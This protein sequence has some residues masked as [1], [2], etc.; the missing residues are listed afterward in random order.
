MST[1]QLSVLYDAPGPKARRRA[2]IGS[3]AVGLAVLAV[4]Y[5]VYARLND[6]GQFDRER[7]APLFDPSD[8]LFDPVW[9]I[10]WSGFRKTMTAA[11]LAIVLSVAIG[12][13][14][15]VARVMFRPAPRVPLVVV[16]EVL[17]G[18]PVIVLIYMAYQLLP[19]LGV[20]YDPLPGENAL[21]YV[22]VGL[23]AYNSVVIAE[24]LRA[25]VASL[26]RGQREAGLVIGLTPLQTMV[27][28]QLPQAFRTML[29]ALISQIVVILKDTSLISFIGGYDELLTTAKR[30]F[31]TANNP[32]QTLLLVGLIFIIINFALSQ[33]AVYAERRMSRRSAGRGINP[34]HLDPSSAG[35]TTA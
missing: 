17:R 6:Q 26:P 4:A 9:E 18:L 35:S 19:D 24:I 22:V 31:Q 7:W 11:A 13:I 21:W 16:I 14:L 15:G 2:L 5:V 8:E 12:T 29:P 32:L 10:L 3:I 27:Q 33:L 28:I 30:I 25:G 23:T 1:S 20:N 34:I